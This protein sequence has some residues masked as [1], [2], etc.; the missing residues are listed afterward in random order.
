MKRFYA[1]TN[2]VQFVHQITKQQRR[3]ELL[4]RI[5]RQHLRTVG[6]DTTESIFATHGRG[7]ANPDANE[8]LG[9]EPMLLD[10]LAS[11]SAVPSEKTPATLGFADEDPMPQ[12][13]PA[14]HYETSQTN[15]H[16]LDLTTWLREH[17]DDPAIRV[18]PTDCLA[19]LSV[20]CV[21]AD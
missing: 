20:M 21:L 16:H 3:V 2:K 8:Y 18:S 14:A 19:R 13:N 9:A 10:R 4:R 5:H 15:R 1:R 11:C 17:R 6:S 7:P 12:S